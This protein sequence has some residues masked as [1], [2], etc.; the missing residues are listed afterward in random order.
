MVLGCCQ[1]FQA[2]PGCGI[3]CQVSGV[4][5]LLQP[6]GER[7]LLP[8]ATTDE[9]LVTPDDPAPTGH[10]GP[11]EPPCYSV[12]IGNREWMRRNGHHVAPDLDAAMSSHET[13]GQTAILVAIDGEDEPPAPNLSPRRFHASPYAVSSTGVLCA[14]LAVADTVKAESALA[15]HTLSG[16]GIEVV[17]ITGDNRRTAKAIAAQVTPGGP[18]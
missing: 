10:P 8:G 13:K 9:S 2:V 3:S 18:C 4:E 12:L 15:V 17:M 1:D 7:F 14:M 16:M 11:G 6:S 5:H